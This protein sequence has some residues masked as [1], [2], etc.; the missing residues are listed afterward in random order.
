[1]NSDEDCTVFLLNIF[2]YTMSEFLGEI[3]I[4][5]KK[6]IRRDDRLFIRFFLSI[7]H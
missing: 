3:E 6:I 7:C 5:N 4:N 1:M 2:F